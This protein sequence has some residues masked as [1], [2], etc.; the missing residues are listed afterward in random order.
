MFC[1]IIYQIYPPLSF[2]GET[3]SKCVCPKVLNTVCRTIGNIYSSL[4]T[5]TAYRHGMFVQ[6]ITRIFLTYKDSGC[7][8]SALRTI[9][10][11]SSTGTINEDL[12]MARTIPAIVIC[13]NIRDRDVSVAA[14]KSLDAM[15]SSSDGD[16]LISQL[17]SPDIAPLRMLVDSAQVDDGILDNMVIVLL[18]KCVQHMDGKAS[19]SRA[20]GIDLL[21]KYFMGCSKDSD[22]YLTVLDSLCLCCR[23]VHGRQKIRDLNGLQMLIDIVQEDSLSSYHE[24]VFSALICYYFDEHT[25]RH[26]V[27]KLNLMKSLVHHLS[28]FSSKLSC[29]ETNNASSSSIIT[30]NVPFDD[31]SS[32]DSDVDIDAPSPDHHSP[33]TTPSDDESECSSVVSTVTSQP[34]ISTKS[35]PTQQQQSTTNATSV[36]FSDE[37]LQSCLSHPV[38]NL[39]SPSSRQASIDIDMSDS[40]PVD[41]I[42]SVLASPSLSYSNIASTNH[43]SSIPLL[44][45]DNGDCVEGKVL[46]LVSRVSHLHDCQPVLATCDIF[47]AIL[48]YFFASHGHNRSQIFKV[49]SK[50]FMNP[51]CF[52]DCLINHA[53]SLLFMHFKTEEGSLQ[54]CS[55]SSPATHSS[56]SKDLFDMLS[57]V[58][59]LPYG[60]GVIA[61]M[62]L[63][64]DDKHVTAGTL[65]LALLEKY[66]SYEVLV[67]N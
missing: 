49:L 55:S 29:E 61:H 32:V 34:I 30:R 3:L 60:Q 39:S 59:R 17:W 35:P 41:Y 67:I 7:L 37:F 16:Y 31:P 46:L 64:G 36:S 25:L 33:S 44:G 53:A 63:R 57:H 21:V 19:V 4:A 45:S 11:L 14:L 48:Q 26:M 38:C 23:D 62:L 20:G 56:L 52:Q 22:L 12:R 13:L 58:A 65:A 66:V 40:M 18:C 2:A 42:D 1:A 47:P 24:N 5:S 9:R 28:L 10:K 51:L 54:S 27:M 8:Q 50:I 6:E 15:I 43:S